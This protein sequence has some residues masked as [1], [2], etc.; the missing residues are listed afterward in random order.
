LGQV[1]PRLPAMARVLGVEV[2]GEAKAFL[3]DESVE[4]ACYA[5]TIAGTP[6]A[7]LWYKPTSTAVAYATRLDGQQLT[8]F[9]DEISPASAPFKDKETGTRWTLAGRGVDGP[10]RGKELTWVNCV[11]CRWFAWAAEYP[12]TLVFNR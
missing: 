1:D 4:R 6:V 7:V 12:D 8:M 10:W 5:D 9:A 2:N 3:L 11:Q